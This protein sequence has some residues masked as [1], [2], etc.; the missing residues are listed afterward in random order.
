M[1]ELPGFVGGAYEARSSSFDAQTSI[2]L[3]LEP[4]APG[5]KAPAALYGTPGLSLFCTV[6]G[7]NGVR[8]LYTASNGRAFVVCGSTLSELL[9]NGTSAVRGTLTST[10]GCV[11]MADNGLELLVV[12]GTSAGYLSPSANAYAAISSSAFYRADR[13]AQ[14]DGYLVLNRPGTGH[15]FLACMTRPPTPAWTSPATG[16]AGPDHCPGR[17]APRNAVLGSH[18]A[19]GSAAAIDTPFAPI[20]GTAHTYGLCGG[21]RHAGRGILLARDRCRQTRAV[22]KLK[23]TNRCASVRRR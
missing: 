3:Y 20:A 16:G 12:D 18:A 11:S 2:N 8:G 14:F 7:T 23:G 15:S 22:M 10:S 5:S 1:P 21:G 13:V 9:A 4:G 19:G 6:S 17:A